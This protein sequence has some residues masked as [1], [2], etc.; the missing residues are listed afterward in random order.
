[1]LEAIMERFGFTKDRKLQEDFPMSAAKDPAW[2]PNRESLDNAS[3][4]EYL[5]WRRQTLD[6]I[7][8]LPPESVEARKLAVFLGR[9]EGMINVSSYSEEDL[10]AE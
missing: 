2:D 1:M 3:D 6:S 9:L 4:T 10:R 8:K 7:A 5:K